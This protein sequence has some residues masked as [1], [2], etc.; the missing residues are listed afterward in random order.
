M[1]VYT[2]YTMYTHDMSIMILFKKGPPRTISI[3]SRIYFLLSFSLT[4]NWLYIV[5]TNAAVMVG[6]RCLF[7]EADGPDNP[8]G[9]TVRVSVTAGPSVLEGEICQ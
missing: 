8:V 4:Y 2:M 6:S 7:S 1:Y 3:F 9:D 5:Y